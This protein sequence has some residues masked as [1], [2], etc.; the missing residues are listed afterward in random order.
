MLLT[1]LTHRDFSHQTGAPTLFENESR[2]QQTGKNC[3][4]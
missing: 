4:K 1:Y 3:G 2:E